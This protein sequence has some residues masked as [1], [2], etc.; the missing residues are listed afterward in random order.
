RDQFLKSFR[1]I[2]ASASRLDLASTLLA[3]RGDRLALYRMC[4]AVVLSAPLFDVPVA[5]CG[6]VEVPFLQI[7]EVDALGRYIAGFGFDPDDLDAAYAELDRR[8]AAGEAAPYART[9]ASLRQFVRAASARAGGRGGTGSSW[10]PC[11]LRTTS[12]RIIVCSA[13]G[14]CTH[15]TST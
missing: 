4:I 11:S 12:W 13:G 14:R 10:P 6:P 9:G 1:P 15:A 2:F 8:Y 7:L 3:T 5:G